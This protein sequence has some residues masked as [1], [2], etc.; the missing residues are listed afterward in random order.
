MIRRPPRSTLFPYTT[1]F[2]SEQLNL[3]FFT[4][5]SSSGSCSNVELVY[6]GAAPNTGSLTVP[7]G[8][9]FPSGPATPVLAAGG[10][11]TLTWNA[12][13][14]TPAP[15]FYRVYRGG[16]L[17]ADRVDTVGADAAT[18]TWADDAPSAG[19]TYYVTAVSANLTESGF[20][21]GITL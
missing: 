21:N 18:L 16:Q 6:G 12:P 9:T 7:L 17:V 8:T 2:R 11:S 4:D 1:L 5:L 19:Q 10:G 3:A 20:S 13:G 14:G 15:L